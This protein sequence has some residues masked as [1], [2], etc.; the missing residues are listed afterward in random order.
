MASSE[1]E[2]STLD[3]RF[4]GYRLRNPAL[5][6]R[7]LSSIAERGIEEP[8]E[9]VD[10]EEERRLLLNGFKRLRCARKLGLSRVPYVS[11]AEDEA[12][13]IVLLLRG[14]NQKSLGILEQAR[15][16][17]DLRDL[18]KMSVAEIAETLSRSKSWVSMRLGLIGEMSETVAKKIF[19]G[20]FPVYPYMYTLRQFMR[21]NGVGKRDIEAFV[22]A[23]SGKKLS[24]REIEH[25]AHGYFRGPAWFRDEILQGHLSLALERLRAVPEN[26]DGCNEFE[27]V[28]VKDLEIVGKYM[29]RVIRKSQSPRLKT[30]PFQA[31]ANLLTAGILS[32]AEGFR[33]AVRELHD[34]TASTPSHLPSSP[35]GDEPSGDRSSTESQP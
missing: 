12:A 13:G 15:F 32:R 25:L 14:S 3:L 24:V 16:I 4:E 20:S 27:R 34:R 6:G 10:Q 7:L 2:V 18:H 5:E 31:Q 8:L 29:Q 23:V 11:M 1:V 22:V 9:G 19:A 35:R 17:E 33:R 30:R 28:F 26:P 21:M